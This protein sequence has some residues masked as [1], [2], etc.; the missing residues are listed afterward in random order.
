MPI[1]PVILVGPRFADLE[2]PMVWNPN[3]AGD[4]AATSPVTPGAGIDVPEG[5]GK[6]TG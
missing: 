1:H 4:S 5:R 6:V 3:A 2:A